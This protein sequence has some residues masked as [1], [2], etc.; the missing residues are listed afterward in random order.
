MTYS[1]LLSI[2]T[3]AVKEDNDSSAYA[4][5]QSVFCILVTV[6]GVGLWSVILE[7]PGRT[8][9]FVSSYANVSSFTCSI[10]Y[11]RQ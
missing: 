2:S 9:L 5:V 8:Y 10:Q 3:I 7:F 11:K 6:P 1:K 4:N